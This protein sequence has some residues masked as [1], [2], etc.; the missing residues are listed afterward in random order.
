MALGTDAP[1]AGQEFAVDARKTAT[2]GTCDSPRGLVAVAAVVHGRRAGRLAVRLARRK[3][4]GGRSPLRCISACP[5]G[6]GHLDAALR[7]PALTPQRQLTYAVG[8]ART[9]PRGSLR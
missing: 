7:R 6:P 9:G 1:E 4:P 2:M 8:P 3:G 5:G